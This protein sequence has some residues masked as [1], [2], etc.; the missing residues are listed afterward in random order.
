MKLLL[1]LAAPLAALALLI[2]SPADL[3]AGGSF[4]LTWTEDPVTAVFYFTEDGEPPLYPLAVSSTFTNRTTA[5][6]PKTTAYVL[7][8]LYIFH[9][10]SVSPF[11]SLHFPLLFVFKKKKAIFFD[12]CLFFIYLLKYADG[13]VTVATS[14]PLERTARAPLAAL[15][16]SPS[17]SHKLRSHL[18]SDSTGHLYTVIQ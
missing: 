17:P 12:M 4:E 1:A 9:L 10:H 3:P 18:Q 11:F 13:L 6:M 15:V 8:S 5:R 16:A 7:L 2:D 14:L